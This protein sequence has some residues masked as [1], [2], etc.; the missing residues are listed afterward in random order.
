MIVR[1]F[2]KVVF[3][4]LYFNICCN[5]RSSRLFVVL[6]MYCTFVYFTFISVLLYVLVNVRTLYID[7]GS[8]NFNK[9]IGINVVIL[10]FLL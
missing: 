1:Q 4:L 6:L 5:K 7:C 3:F 10:L 9:E 2:V 8:C